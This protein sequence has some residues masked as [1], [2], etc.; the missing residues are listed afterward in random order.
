[1]FGLKTIFGL[2]VHVLVV[3]FAV[4]VVPLAAIG[5]MATGWRTD[6]RTRFSFPV[7]LVS[8]VGAA[9]AFLAAQSGG[10]LRRS[11]RATAAAS[12][13]RADFGSHPSDGDIARI[14][15][16]LLAA[17][18]IAIWFNERTGKAMWPPIA[19]YGVGF[20]LAGVALATMVLAGHSGAALVWKDL[21]N[22]VRP[23]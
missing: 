22:Y 18:A 13:R 9:A 11:I 3:H 23:H 12:G 10:E 2:P 8:V 6:W 20:V 16:I 7:A 17:A 21:G 14:L 1:V 15:A 19:I 5:L 4:A